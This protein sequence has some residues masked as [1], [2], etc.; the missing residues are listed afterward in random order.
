[1]PSAS[2]DAKRAQARLCVIASGQGVAWVQRD[3]R[4]LL[5]LCANASD[6]GYATDPHPFTIP[7]LESEPRAITETGVQPPPLQGKPPWSAQTWPSPSVEVSAYQRLA[8]QALPN[9]LG[10]LQAGAGKSQNPFSQAHTSKQVTLL[11]FQME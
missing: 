3:G 11:Q 4:I 6:P 9:I 2:I 10:A 7:P 8:H 5:T 1:M